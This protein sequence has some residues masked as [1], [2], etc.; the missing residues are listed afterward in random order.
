M[1]QFTFKSKI[2]SGLLAVLLCGAFVFWNI[3]HNSKRFSP[4]KVSGFLPHHPEWDVPLTSDA[5]ATLSH[6][7]NQ[8]F[9]YLGV[10]VQTFAFVSHDGKYVIKF[11]KAPPAST[12]EKYEKRMDKL[13][14]AIDAYYMAYQEIPEDT[15][16]LFVHLTPTASLQKTVMVSDRS[17]KKHLIDLDT[18]P[19]IVQ[20]KAELIF[21]RFKRLVLH[22][23]ARGLKTS[24]TAVLELVNRRIQKGFTDDDKA[25][26]HNY[27]FVGDRPIH[28]DIGR[29][30]KGEREGEYEY[31]V[32]RIDSW[33]LQDAEK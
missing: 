11:F 13:I 20:E 33:L 27:G 25:V 1:A 4:S 16:L 10:G 31:I 26:T 24:V 2:L 7:F 30:H 12:Q 15:G 22:G 8:P 5:Q 6:V 14:I 3:S 23:D 21:D 28:F 9:S 19:F 17:G 18:A 32:D 29:M